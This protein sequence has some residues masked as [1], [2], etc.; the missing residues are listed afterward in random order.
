MLTVLTLFVLFKNGVDPKVVL[1][2]FFFGARHFLV[3]DQ[4]QQLQVRTRVFQGQESRTIVM[5]LRRIQHG[6]IRPIFFEGMDGP[7][8]F[9]RY[10]F[11]LIVSNGCLGLGFAI[12]KLFIKRCYLPIDA[13]LLG[14]IALFEFCPFLFN[15][16]DKFLSR[17]LFVPQA[18]LGKL[19]EMALLHEM[20]VGEDG[21]V[22]LHDVLHPLDQFVL[23]QL[24]GLASLRCLRCPLLLLH[25][26]SFVME[27]L[28]LVL[29]LLDL[30]SLVYFLPELP[31]SYISNVGSCTLPRFFL[32]CMVERS[33]AQG[34]A[35]VIGQPLLELLL[36]SVQL[37]K[38]FTH[39]VHTLLLSTPIKLVSIP[40]K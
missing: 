18:V 24:D 12:I 29:D 32:L 16:A 25:Q 9:R 4:L 2:R 28:D 34:I 21:V 39:A 11:S 10:C 38:S 23:G 26:L 37:L 17:G 6:I 27:S 40:E 8:R 31:Q 5:S 1:W 7:G 19:M 35:P 33:G 36:L 30:G 15:L 14:H 3:L 13:N 20:A 22:L